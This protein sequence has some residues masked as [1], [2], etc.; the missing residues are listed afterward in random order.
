MSKEFRHFQRIVKIHTD[1]SDY[2]LRCAEITT[3]DDLVLLFNDLSQNRI[4]MANSLLSA[5]PDDE[6]RGFWRM[7]EALSYLQRI[8]YNVKVALIVNDRSKIL[9]YCQKAEWDAL[10]EYDKALRRTNSPSEALLRHLTAHQQMLRA[11]I[12]RIENMPKKKSTLQQ[13][14]M[15]A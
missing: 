13:N 7:R 4:N 8:W 1:T 14:R 10:Q 9:K 12:E 15:A 11:S 6:R 2:Y 3:E 5:L